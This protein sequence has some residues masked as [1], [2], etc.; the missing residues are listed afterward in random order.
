VSAPDG[1]AIPPDIDGRRS[2]DDFLAEQGN[3]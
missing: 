1:Q 3:S 2:N